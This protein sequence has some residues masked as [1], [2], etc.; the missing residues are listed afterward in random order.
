MRNSR[1]VDRAEIRSM[2]YTYRSSNIDS[3]LNRDGYALVRG[4]LNS[5]S[6]ARAADDCAAALMSGEAADSVLTSRPGRAYGARNLLRLWPGA[7]DLL[8]QSPLAAVLKDIL[9]EAAGVVRGLYFDKPPGESWSLPWHRDMTIAVKSHGPLGRFNKPTT[10]AGVPHL[11][12]P[13]DLLATML[14]AR[15][16]L[17]AMTAENGPLQ[18][19][20]G[21]HRLDAAPRPV[22]TIHC[23][24]GDVLL[25]RPL[26]S[27]ASIVSAEGCTEHRRIVHLEM[28]PT[29]EL[30]DGYEWHDWVALGCR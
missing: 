1:Y 4:V 16:H 9:G 15:I 26:V 10:K 12:A 21:S 14:T 20:P 19:V 2:E 23:A 11:E 22:E 3:L 24:A 7:V 6:V 27:H 29:K 28:S 18:V 30:S 8:R 5:D 13:V 17:D 25:M